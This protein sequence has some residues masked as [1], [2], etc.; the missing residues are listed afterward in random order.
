VKIY[1]S[2]TRK[3]EEF[4]PINKSR[5]S[6]YVCGPTVYDEPH[7]GH[8]RSAYIFDFV[9]RYLAYR[10]LKVTFVRNVTDVDDKIIDKAKKESASVTDVSK[11]YLDAYH[12]DMGIL[13]IASPTKNLKLPSISQRWSNL[14]SFS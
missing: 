8:A 13:G 11:K 1:N 12:R 10:G 5:V 9:R 7:I 14:S 6:M 3:K 4:T 2:L